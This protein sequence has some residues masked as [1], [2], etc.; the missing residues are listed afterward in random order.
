MK[1]LLSGR[2]WVVG[3]LVLAVALVGVGIAIPVL[4]SPRNAP[5][6]PVNTYGGVYFDS[7]TLARLAGIL[8]LTPA[9]LTSQL[10]SGKTL[11]QIA[12]SKNI[13]TGTLV[14]AIVAPYADQVALQLKY[15]Y[16]T[17][18]QSQS[19][20][21]AAR[22][23]ANTLLTQDLSTSQ[24]YSNGY[25]GGCG[26]YMAGGSYGPGYGWGMMGPGMMGGWG[27]YY[28]QPATP[29]TNPPTT[30]TTPG[31]T[32]LPGQTYNGGGWGMMGGMMGRW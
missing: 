18:E 11:A 31:G 29:G 22:Q 9:D 20:L 23:R 28:N 4:A 27:G 15:G 13:S 3:V 26:S 19:L 17:Q 25:F 24:G 7:S 12:Q 2:K 8:G 21:D 1:R 5:T 30:P 6:A 14:D 32:T 16:I 10:Q